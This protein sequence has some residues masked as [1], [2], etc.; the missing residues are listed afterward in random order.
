MINT[1]E[2]I[3]HKNRDLTDEEIEKLRADRLKMS[4]LKVCAKWQI[5]QRRCAEYCAGIR[6]RKVSKPK[7]KP[8]HSEFLDER[9]HGYAFDFLKSFK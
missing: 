6:E 2:F 8:K 4:F 9:V 1:P 5:T 3:A 7:P